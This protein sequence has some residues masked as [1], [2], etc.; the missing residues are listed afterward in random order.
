MKGVRIAAEWL[1]V[2]A[3]PL[4]LIGGSV[5]WAV[6]D[7]GLYR[8]G[9]A[10][11]DISLYTGITSADLE[12][13][14]GDLRRYFNSTEE[15]LSVQVAIFGLERDLFNQREVA[16]MRDVKRLIWGTYAVAAAAGLYLLTVIIAGFV[17]QGRA[18]TPWLARRLLAGGLATLGLIAAVGGFALVGFDSLF[19]LFHRI[20]FA[21]DLWQLD[22]R[23]D[24]LLI[25]F[26]LGFWFDATIRVALTA[27]AGAVVLAVMGGGYWVYRRRGFSHPGG[28]E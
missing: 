16:H 19:L 27:A 13:V 8:R 10:R 17:R 14:G 5:A 9:F 7:G 21:N 28:A 18:F 12:R 3:V 23:T 24:Y 4:L 22:P 6:N 25:M 15:P 20:S 2:L 1:F 26:P 11:Y